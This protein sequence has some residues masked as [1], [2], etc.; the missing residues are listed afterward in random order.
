M[1]AWQLGNLYLLM[2]FMGIAVLHSTTETSVV[3]AYLFVLAV[4]DV[5]HVGLTAY[6]MGLN[7]LSRPVAWNAMTI[8]NVAFTL[9]LFVMR[10]LYFI[11]CF[12]PDRTAPSLA[13]KKEKK[14]Q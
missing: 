5:G 11:G 7:K 6:G 3:R 9:F 4:G 10:S 2:A 12:G 1:V 14:G 8:G 13:E